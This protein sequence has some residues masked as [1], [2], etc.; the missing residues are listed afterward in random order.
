MDFLHVV[1]RNAFHPDRLPD[2][3]RRGVPDAAVIEALFAS[4]L[5]SEI[6]RIGN[7]DDYAVFAFSNFARNVHRKR[8]VAA[9]VIAAESAVYVNFAFIID[10]AEIQQHAVLYETLRNFKRF[11]I[12]QNVVRHNH[13]LNAREHAFR[14]KRHH[15]FAVVRGR[16]IH[17]FGYG[18]IPHAV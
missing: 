5:R 13:F 18:I 15:D 1:F 10:C 17:G 11:F 12:V 8:I 14:S 7:F 16:S 2:A 3:A 6:G 9:D 4:C